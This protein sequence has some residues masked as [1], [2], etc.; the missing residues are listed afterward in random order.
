MELYNLVIR[1][2]TIRL[3]GNI[4]EEL[5]SQV[6][7]IANSI[8]F[9]TGFP[10]DSDYERFVQRFIEEV[11]KTLNIELKRKNIAGIFRVRDK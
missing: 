5:F 2:R 9:V 1:G 4:P 6:E 7:E 3:E 11:Q 10:L 8:E